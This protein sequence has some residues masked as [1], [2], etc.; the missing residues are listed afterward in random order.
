MASVNSNQR[1]AQTITA[2][3][4]KYIRPYHSKPASTL[5]GCARLLGLRLRPVSG[6]SAGRVCAGQSVS[7]TACS[8]SGLT[9]TVTA[10]RV[11]FARHV[12]LTRSFTREMKRLW[13]RNLFIFLCRDVNGWGQCWWS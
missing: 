4:R 6:G 10:L 9:S 1:G 8:R 3:P 5:H 2:D 12:P 11:L 7:T 13:L